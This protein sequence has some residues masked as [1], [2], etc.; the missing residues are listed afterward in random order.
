MADDFVEVVVDR[1]GNDL[2]PLLSSGLKVYG[3]GNWG[4]LYV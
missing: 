1:G 3:G 2:P 4:R